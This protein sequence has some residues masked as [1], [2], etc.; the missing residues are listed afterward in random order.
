MA[1]IVSQFLRN[2]CWSNS[3]TVE[4]FWKFCPE[5]KWRRKYFNFLAWILK[6]VDILVFEQKTGILAQWVNMRAILLIYMLH[7]TKNIL[8]GLQVC[9]F[10]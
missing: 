4:N 1:K 3:K 5:C 10:S 6:N 2:V 7:F 9:K 8:F